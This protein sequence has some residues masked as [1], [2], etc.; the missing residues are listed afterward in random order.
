MEKK[1]RDG[2]RCFSDPHLFFSHT[3]IM[4]SSPTILLPYPSIFL[5][6]VPLSLPCLFPLFLSSIPPALIV[7]P[8]T[9][10]VPSICP[11]FVFVFA[12]GMVR[13]ALPV[14]PSLHHLSH[15]VQREREAE[16]RDENRGLGGGGTTRG[17]GER[18]GGRSETKRE[19]R[20]ASW[21]NEHGRRMITIE[22][23]MLLLVEA[24][25]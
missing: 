16:R 4:S 9:Y 22:Y 2:G 13:D 8:A 11:L 18:K 7:L 12:F 23:I 14:I 5:A 3:C 17:A 25:N 19:D 21:L 20:A 1:I 24:I 6:I 15:P 10:S